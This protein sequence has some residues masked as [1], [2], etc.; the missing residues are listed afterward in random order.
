MKSSSLA[1][2]IL[3]ALL[4]PMVLA[5]PA[6]PA[7]TNQADWNFVVSGDSRNC[8]DVVMPAI[9]AGAIKNNAAFYWHLGDLRAIYGIDEDYQHEPEHRGRTISKDDYLKDAWDDFI[10]N[11]LASFGAV[12]VF[13]GIGN[14]ETT[15]PKTREQFAE[16]FVQWLDAPALKQQR[17]ADNSTDSAPRTYFH[18]IQGGV[19]FIYLDNATQDQFAPEQVAWVEGVLQRAMAN[20][21]V[22]AVVVGMHAALPD[23]LAFGHSMSDWLIGVESGRRVYS[24]LLNFKKKTHKHVYLLASHSHFYMSGIFNSPYWRAHGGELPGRIVGTA[25][26]IRYALPPDAPRAREART[27]IYGFLLG[28]VHP[29]GEIDFKFHEVKKPDV[30]GAVA[31]RYTPEFVDYCFDKNIASPQIAEPNEKPA[32]KK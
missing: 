13:V 15:A 12:P 25:G 30:P 6:S 16:K 27:N 9:A 5:Q 8:G 18:W 32:M 24:D 7:H 22:R 1:S 4:A 29:G 19:D 14:H 10:Q 11:Q 21:A 17:L 3:L 26:A 20:S 2:A 31:Q 28:T 23:S